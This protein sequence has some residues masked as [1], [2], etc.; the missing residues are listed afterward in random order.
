MCKHILNAQVQIRAPC[1]KTWF[2]CAECHAETQKHGLPKTL[3][4]TF[5]CKKC[6]KAFR[7]DMA[8]Y[9]E[10]DE[11]LLIRV[12]V[13]EAKTPQA[14]VKVEGE[15]VRVDA[16]MLKDDR[17]KVIQPRPELLDDDDDFFADRLGWESNAI[18]FASAS[19]CG[20][21]S[22]RS[23][24]RRTFSNTAYT[25]PSASSSYRPPRFE[26]H[27]VLPVR[28]DHRTLTQEIIYANEQAG[29]E[30]DTL[31]SRRIRSFS[32]R[33]PPQ[34]ERHR[35]PPVR[36]APK[37]ALYHGAAR[38]AA[39]LLLLM[40]F[41]LDAATSVS[42]TQSSTLYTFAND[43]LSFDVVK[44][45]GYIRNLVYRNTSMLGPLSGNAGQLYTDF[46][47]GIFSAGT[48][49]TSARIV[50]GAGWAGIVLTDEVAAV[51]TLVQRS[52][53]LRNGDSGLHSFLRLAYHSVSNS[54]PSLGPLGESRTMFRP[55][56]PLWRSMATVFALTGG[57]GAGAVGGGAREPGG[58]SRRNMVPRRYAVRRVCSPGIRLLDQTGLAV[59][60]HCFETTSSSDPP[61]FFFD[62]DTSTFSIPMD[63]GTGNLDSTASPDALSNTAV[64]TATPEA[65][66]KKRNR[67]CGAEKR[68]RQKLRA[69]EEA[70]RAKDTSVSL[71][72][73][74]KLPALLSVASVVHTSPYPAPSEN[75]HPRTPGASPCIASIMTVADIPR[76]TP[77]HARSRSLSPSEAE[78][79]IADSQPPLPPSEWPDHIR[80]FVYG[81]NPPPY[82][83]PGYRDE[84]VLALVDDDDLG[85]LHAMLERVPTSWADDVPDV[86]P[87]ASVMATLP[88]RDLSALRGPNPWRGIRR[89][90]RRMRANRVWVPTTPTPAA[91]PATPPLDVPVHNISDACSGTARASA[92]RNILL[93]APTLRAHPVDPVVDIPYAPLPPPSLCP[94]PDEHIP[95]PF[96]AATRY[97]DVNS[98]LPF[99]CVLALPPPRESV[100]T[101]ASVVWPFP[102][103]DGST[104]FAPGAPLEAI[105]GLRP[106]LL[107]FAAAVAQMVHLEEA[108]AWAFRDGL[109]RLV[110]AAA[111]EMD[112]VVDVL[113]HG[114]GHEAVPGV[115]AL[116]VTPLGGGCE[117]R[118]LISGPD[119]SSA[120]TRSPTTRQTK[121][122]ACT[123][124]PGNSETSFGAWWV[125]NQKDTFF[126]GPLHIDLMVDGI[127]YNKQ[128]TSHGGATSPNITN[129]FD[130]TF[131]PQFLYF[132]SG[133]NATLHALLADAERLADPE[134]NSA[135]Y[136]EIAPFVVG[137][138]PSSGRG[139]FSTDVA[140]PAGATEGTAMAVLSANGVHFQD[141]AADTSAYQYWGT[142]DAEGRLDIPRVKAGR[143]RLTVFASGI[144]G[145]FVKDGIVVTAGTNT[146]VSVSWVAESAGKELWR[147][148]TPDK[149]AGEFRN[150]HERDETHSLRPASAWDFPTQFP[151]G[152]NFTIGQ[153]VEGVDWNYIHW[154]Q[155]GVTH[156]N[157][158]VVTAFNNW[159]INFVLHDIPAADSVATFT[160]QLAGAKTTAGNTDEQTGSNP[161]FSISTYVNGEPTPLAWV[162][163]A[164]ESSSCGQRS[165][166]CI[167]E[168]PSSVH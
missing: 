115:L 70:A 19:T 95:P 138:V 50:S 143:Y 147:L 128:S 36:P 7:K 154:S 20:T 110:E 67:L 59:T 151:N 100:D 131:G 74:S 34:S 81:R 112:R 160:M 1:C 5:M 48:G 109:C 117:P 146:Q 3:E 105:R 73:T 134:W 167:L 2:D 127:A 165:G 141:N 15:D 42:V 94:F 149:S 102:A 71:P 69:Q 119:L 99:A 32:S 53:F 114:R 24:A 77:P 104:T 161:S 78:Y 142:L 31:L 21:R 16:R 45:N 6:R 46:P 113:A 137:Y 126:G 123:P 60:Q 139:G 4:M 120:S 75:D 82:A 62:N 88:P 41:L 166:S 96:P 40:Y 12:Q 85:P 72:D 25:S 56:S 108:C 83:R 33:R 153:S 163:Q 145:D 133:Q 43:L 28:N 106:D 98:A 79:S 80:E 18:C 22:P 17:V 159:Q 27:R 13:I 68:K 76:Y 91:L 164:Y 156:L 65:E 103:A 144:F 63:P 122:T 37:K 39:L 125:V 158:R 8:V 97:G 90:Q 140:L 52:W 11:Y 47:S 150:G 51:G 44:T 168:L 58:G 57:T 152:V 124:P 14:V 118:W 30:S 93:D 135:F 129:G 64:D 157:P 54:A 23:P 10:S 107:V 38:M 155:F 26:R 136:D 92:P 111:D 55:N 162:I 86:V 87:I 89:R 101:I 61:H 84:P 121:P 66:K 132:N 35:I 116:L 9:E 148:G 49:N 130:R 29:R